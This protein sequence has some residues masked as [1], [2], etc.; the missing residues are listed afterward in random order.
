[1]IFDKCSLQVKT[2]VVLGDLGYMLSLV[3]R[4]CG[5]PNLSCLNP[6]VNPLNNRKHPSQALEGV[7]QGQCP[8]RL[9]GDQ[10]AISLCAH[11]VESCRASRS[12]LE[13]THSLLSF[14]ST[15]VCL[16]GYVNIQHII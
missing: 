3:I 11:T 14:L 13:D 8:N 9:G 1:M 4:D 12:L 10:R 15:E 2:W 6:L 5:N 7:V 16:L